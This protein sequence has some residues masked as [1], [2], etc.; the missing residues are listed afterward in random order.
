MRVYIVH[1]ILSYIIRYSK[2]YILRYIRK[3]IAF[4]TGF[5]FHI[6]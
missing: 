5:L 2:D 6:T 4:T 3:C 1:I